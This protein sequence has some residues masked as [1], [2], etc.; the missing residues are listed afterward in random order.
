MCCFLEEF[1]RLI[2]QLLIYYSGFF[3]PLGFFCFCWN[4]YYSVMICSHFM[5]FPSFGNIKHTCFKSCLEHSVYCISSAYVF[6]HLLD[7]S[8]IFHAVDFLQKL[9]ISCFST[10]VFLLWFLCLPP[11]IFLSDS[12]FPWFP[13]ECSQFSIET[14]LII[15]N[16]AIFI[17]KYLKHILYYFS[18]LSVERGYFCICW[19]CLLKFC[20]IFSY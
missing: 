14:Y 4:I 6:F 7:L 19:F 15:L 16:A 5:V 11:L 1:F 13:W 9:G 12:V 18:V 17:L 20:F 2:V 8:S 3:S 10:A